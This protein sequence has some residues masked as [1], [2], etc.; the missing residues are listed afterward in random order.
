V[1]EILRVERH[2]KEVRRVNSFTYMEDRNFSKGRK[3]LG[4]SDAFT[5][6]GQN[7]YQTPMQL[8]EIMTGRA[9]GFKGSKRTRAGNLK[10]ASILSTNMM[11]YGGVPAQVANEF[12]VSRIWGDNRYG[13]YHSWTEAKFSDGIIAHTDLLDL[14][15]EESPMLWQA[16][17]TGEFAAAARKRDANKGYDKE[18]LTANGIP[19]SVY[20]QQQIEMTCYQVRQCKVAVEIGGWDYITYG[21]IDYNKKVAENLIALYERMLWHIAKDEPPTPKTWEDVVKLFPEFTPD[22][23]TVLNPDEEVEARQMLDEHSKLSQRI[24]ELEG[25]KDNI[26]NALGLLIGGSNYLQTITGDS[27]ASASVIKGRDNVSV[28]ALKKFE[29]LYAEVEAAG[30]IK[31]SED[32]RQLYIKSAPAGNIDRFTLLTTDDGDKWKRGRKKYTAA[33]KK[34]SSALLKSLK[35]EHKWEKV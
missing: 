16:K 4:A 18:D 31:K 9:S 1:G 19:L 8:W 17:N 10:E 7:P 34:E 12:L 25:R 11:L 2:A 21:P 13:D 35:I 24:K 23:K 33:E 30:L 3:Y 27:I 5:I 29:K 22:T 26:K 14:T 20:F 15:D 32:Y 28:S 6:S